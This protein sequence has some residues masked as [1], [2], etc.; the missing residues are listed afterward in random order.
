MTS[1]S[2]ALRRCEPRRPHATWAVVRRTIDRLAHRMLGMDLSRL[3]WLEVERLTPPAA[4]ISEGLSQLSCDENGTVPFRNAAIE[5]RFLG[6]DEVGRL[7]ADPDNHLDPAM[8]D[9]AFAGGGLCFAALAGGRLAA[10]GWFVAGE[11]DPR[12]CGGVRL[13]LPAEAAY[14]YNG[15]THPEFRGRRLYG[16]LMSRGLRALADRGV[17]RL[18]TSVAWTNAPALTSCRRL[19]YE[20]LG[21]FL[22]IGRGRWRLVFP[23]RAARRRGIGFR[24]C[25][26]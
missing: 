10:Y 4:G 6:P 23:P 25:V 12:H 26:T 24:V 5:F 15:F 9:P 14:F 3:L 20:D 7:A 22:G 11:V 1:G 13:S 19:G 2:V 21:C 18:L 8:A 17:R 16:Q